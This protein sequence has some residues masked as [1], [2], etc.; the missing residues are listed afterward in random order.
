MKTI[1][2][3]ELKHLAP[4]LPYGLKAL[5]K[6]P[7]GDPLISDITVDNIMSFV[8]GDIDRK[9]ILRPLTDLNKEIPHPVTGDV[10][11]VI[12]FLDD[13]FAHHLHEEDSYEDHFKQAVEEETGLLDFSYGVIDRLHEWHFDTFGLIDAGLAVDINTLEL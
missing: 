7:N 2:K 5:G 6:Y 9:P 13:E 3:L 1:E 4:Y 8:D 11:E 12:E 10:F